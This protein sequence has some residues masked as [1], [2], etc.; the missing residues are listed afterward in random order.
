MENAVTAIIILTILLVLVCVNTYMDVE[1]FTQN[2]INVSK[3][4]YFKTFS[5]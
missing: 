4:G 5:D 2:S 1:R 3:G